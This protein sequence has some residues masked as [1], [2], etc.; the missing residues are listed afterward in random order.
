VTSAI[1][2]SVVGVQV[3]ESIRI[4]L[5]T[6]KAS[7]VFAL[8]T[9]FA[10]IIGKLVPPGFVLIARAE[11]PRRFTVALVVAIRSA[12]LRCLVPVFIPRALSCRVGSK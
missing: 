3:V 11:W 10:N 4:R 7:A 12:T 8:A 6:G 1:A 5:S 9:V 2:S